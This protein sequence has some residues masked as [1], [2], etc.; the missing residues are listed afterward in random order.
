MGKHSLKFGGEIHYDDVRNAAYGNAR[1]SI[2]FLGGVVSPNPGPNG[3]SPLEDFFAGAPLKSTVTVGNP[4][5]QLHNWA[6]AGFFQDDFRATRNLTINFGVRYEF[7]TVPQEAHNL[8]GNFDPNVGLVQVGHQISS[9]WNPDHTNFGPRFGFAWDIGGNGR[10]VLRGG[11]GLIYETVNW[12]SFVAF[13]NAFGPGSVPTG[14][15]IDAA[16]DTSGGTITTGNL[17]VKNI[18]NYPTTWD[19]ANGP[20]YGGSKIN[21]FNS[22]CPI[23]TVSR[24]LTTPYVW[25]WT[26]NVQ[27]AFT[28]NLS[29]EAA[30]SGKSRHEFDRN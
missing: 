5:L 4:T 30:Y 12:Q 10:T 20:L 22:P 26:L 27:H 1:G 19:A 29:I 28:T 3:L 9:L 18:A 23:M 17:T 2:N 11:G 21:C 16:G 24:G 25:N 13:N 14:A 6:Y 8:L 7:S 15:P